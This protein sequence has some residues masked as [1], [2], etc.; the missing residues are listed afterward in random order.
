MKRSMALN[1]IKIA[2]WD[3]DREQ[4]VVLAAKHG[5]G[6][7]AYL[8]AFIDGQKIKSRGEPRPENMKK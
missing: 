6:K 2:G 3:G 7:V 4:A 8:K 1:E 5:I